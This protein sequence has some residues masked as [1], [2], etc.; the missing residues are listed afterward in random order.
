MQKLAVMDISEVRTPADAEPQGRP[1]PNAADRPQAHAPMPHPSLVK[2][3]EEGCATAVIT[4]NRW[5]IGAGIVGAI[6]GGLFGVIVAFFRGWVADLGTTLV[7]AAMGILFMGLGT[8]FLLGIAGYFVGMA[9]GAVQ[10]ARA[11]WGESAVR[12]PSVPFG[13]H[14]HNHRA[15]V[16]TGNALTSPVGSVDGMG[17]AAPRV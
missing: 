15:A 8:G 6:F 16:A 3:I 12:R 1:L 11:A 2:A 13:E 17:V 10:G 14:L 4:A 5:A 9:C 7:L